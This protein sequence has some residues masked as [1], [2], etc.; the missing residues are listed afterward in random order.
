[1]SDKNLGTLDV[2]LREI[3]NRA[4]P[5]GGFTIVFA[6]DFRQLEPVGSTE[7]D[8]LFSSLSSKHWDN[9]I[10]AIIILE[11][12]HHFKEDPE[13]GQM[14][15]RMWNGDL[16]TEDRK[17]I[18]SRVIGYNDLELPS[19][20]E[21]G[22]SKRNIQNW[23]NTSKYSAALINVFIAKIKFMSKETFVM[24]AQRTKNKMLSSQQYFR[25]I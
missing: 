15:K 22:F 11:N 4:K 13:Y 10:N 2:K 24:P 18:N 5:F 14:L 16:T 21:D 17:R 1:M 23:K 8:L 3:G 7:I 19:Y 9:Y 20:I 12:D 6:G 25:S